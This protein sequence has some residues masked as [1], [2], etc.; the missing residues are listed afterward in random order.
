M[1]EEKPKRTFVKRAVMP[2]R[3][4]KYL[5]LRSLQ[6]SAGPGV[7]GSLHFVGRIILGVRGIPNEYHGREETEDGVVTA[8]Q[9]AFVQAI[10]RIGV[11][12]PPMRIAS[13]SIGTAGRHRQR[14]DAP[15]IVRAKLR[16]DGWEGRLT[17]RHPDGATAAALAYFDAYDG[18]LYAQWKRQ[19]APA[20]ITPE[21]AIAQR[22]LRE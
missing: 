21:E 7:D 5:I 14:P 8:L 4:G 10:R 13:F 6:Y 18:L 3:E 1:G 2:F 20:H 17:V 9:R 11:E 15:A 19:L 16:L 22:A 12:M